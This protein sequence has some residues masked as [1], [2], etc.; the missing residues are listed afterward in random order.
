M[1]PYTACVVS[2]Y[3][4]NKAEHDV[5]RDREAHDTIISTFDWTKREVDINTF[6]WTMQEVDKNTCG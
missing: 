1:K 2:V 4:F 3:I 6:G 5:G